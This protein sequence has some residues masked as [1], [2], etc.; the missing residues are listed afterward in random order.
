MP[1]RQRSDPPSPTPA[2]Y[3]HSEAWLEIGERL[4]RVAAFGD[5]TPL[6]LLVL[7][8]CDYFGSRP[9]APGYVRASSR[10]TEVGTSGSLSMGNFVKGCRWP[11]GQLRGGT[12]AS[13]GWIG[14]KALSGSCRRFRKMADFSVTTLHYRLAANTDLRPSLPPYCRAIALVTAIRYST[15]AV[16]G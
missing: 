4:H 8:G 9:P 7:S 3:D 14:H 12:N 6:A 2:G 10:H 13:R 1:D 5:L 15:F 16:I 11:H